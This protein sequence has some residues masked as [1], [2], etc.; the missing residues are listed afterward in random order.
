MRPD[1]TMRPAPFTRWSLSVTRKTRKAGL[2]GAARWRSAGVAVFKLWGEHAGLRDAQT[3][4][5]SVCV[6]GGW[7][8]IGAAPVRW[9][10][11]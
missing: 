10:R 7:T 4:R 11:L 5:I 2:A 3:G 9:L 1:I 6:R 8:V